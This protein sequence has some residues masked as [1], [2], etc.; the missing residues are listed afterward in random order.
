MDRWPMHHNA[1]F[2]I[3]IK[4]NWSSCIMG[5][6]FH[7]YIYCIYILYIY[8]IYNV[9]ICYCNIIHIHTTL[10]MSPPAPGSM[11]FPQSCRVGCSKTM[12]F[13]ACLHLY[14]QD[15]SKAPVFSMFSWCQ[16]QKTPLCTLFRGPPP[17]KHKNIAVFCRTCTRNKSNIL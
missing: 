6:I 8:T 2:L 14:K 3:P 10:R 4:L 5:F 17:R 7:S 1:S 9:D 11:F 13:T 15:T 16:M 12:C